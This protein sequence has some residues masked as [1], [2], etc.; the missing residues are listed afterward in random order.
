MKFRILPKFDNREDWLKWRS[1]GIGASDASIIMGVSRFKTREQ[2]V[3]EKALGIIDEQNSYIIKRGNDVEFQVRKYF[4]NTERINYE[5]SNTQCLWFPFIRASLDGSDNDYK[6]IMEVKLLAVVDSEQP[7]WSTKGGKK[8]WDLKETG[9][10]PDEY[11]PQVQLQLFVTGAEKCKFV[12]YKETKGNQVIT[13][14][15]LAITEVKP[16]KEYQRNLV[17]KLVDFWLDVQYT[18]ENNKYK[19]ELE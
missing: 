4:E 7:I 14:D 15:K 5:A 1:Q 8:W 11:Y 3:K 17:H 19:G 16:D 2:L 10:V 12:G 18:K 6:I 13:S 9:K